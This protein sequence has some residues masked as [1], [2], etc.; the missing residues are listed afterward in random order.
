[1]NEY[2]P[3]PIM[4]ISDRLK[5]LGDPVGKTMKEII[6]VIGYPL[7]E[8]MNTLCVVEGVPFVC[9]WL[10]DDKPYILLFDHNYI[11]VDDGIYDRIMSDFFRNYFHK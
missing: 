9:G 3:P 1:M 2:Y 10:A 4:N 11:C 6:G 8:M 7:D 5:Q